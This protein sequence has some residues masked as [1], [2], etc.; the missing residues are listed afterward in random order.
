MGFLAFALFGDPYLLE[1]I[2]DVTV[3]KVAWA[4]LALHLLFWIGKFIWTFVVY[5]KFYVKK[6]IPINKEPIVKVENN[7]P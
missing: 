4:V 6:I 2:V 5:F 7:P 1:G 3:L